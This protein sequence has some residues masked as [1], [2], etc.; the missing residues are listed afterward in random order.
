[1]DERDWHHPSMRDDTTSTN[2]E[3]DSARRR[4]SPPPSALRTERLRQGLSQLELAARSGLSPGWISALERSPEFIT[5][6][7]AQR[8]AEV[9]GVS[10]EDLRP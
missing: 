1:M 4:R 10:A 6:R 3:H 7:T 5:E 9:L 8:L 2:A